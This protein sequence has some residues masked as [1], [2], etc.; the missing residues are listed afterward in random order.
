MHGLVDWWLHFTGA[1]DGS[2]AWY[3]WWSGFVGDLV[4]LGVIVGLVRTANC[5]APGCW[6]PGFHPVAGT[7]FK[8]CKRHHPTGGHSLD[9]IHA[10]H[11]AH[12]AQLEVPCPEP[13]PVGGITTPPT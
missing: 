3:L 5:H 8:T 2:G 4:Y 12:M 10:I 9:E 1:D 6:R 11:A 7:R 13:D